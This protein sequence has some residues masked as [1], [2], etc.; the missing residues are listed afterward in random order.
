MCQRHG[1]KKE[2]R[3][4]KDDRV[5][6]EK[7]KRRGRKRDDGVVEQLCQG[8]REKAASGTQKDDMVVERVCQGHK[9]KAASMM[10]RDDRVVEYARGT[11]RESRVGDTKGRQGRRMSVPGAQR[12]GGADDDSLTASG[13]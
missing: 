1:K 3:T 5:I 9:E 4:Q 13:S 10:Q 11:R 7:R 12:V 8:H 2:L 6:D